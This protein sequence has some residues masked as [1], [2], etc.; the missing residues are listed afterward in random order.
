[1]NFDLRTIPIDEDMAEVIMGAL[2]MAYSEGTTDIRTPDKG[3]DYDE[4]ERRVV[5]VINTLYPDLVSEYSHLP[6]VQAL[7][8]K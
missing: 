6:S 5:R 1:M 3:K 7:K 4:V 8:G 2:S